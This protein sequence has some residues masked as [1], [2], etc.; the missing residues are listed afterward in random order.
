MQGFGAVAVLNLALMSGNVAGRSK[1]VVA[2]S[3]VFMYVG[4][5]FFHQTSSLT[6]RFWPV[7]G[8]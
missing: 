8:P 5:S 6:A 3:L 2:S 4:S 1:Q 7:H